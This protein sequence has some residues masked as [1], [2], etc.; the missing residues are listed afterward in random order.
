[1]LAKI[2]KNKPRREQEYVIAL[3]R[4]AAADL[5][6]GNR[7]SA[8]LVGLAVYLKKKGDNRLADKYM[9]IVGE[10]LDGVVPGEDLG[11]LL[12]EIKEV[13][14]DLVR[15]A[16]DKRIVNYIVLVVLAAAAC[17]ATLAWRRARRRERERYEANVSLNSSVVTRDE[18]IRQLL[19]ICSAYQ[20]ASAAFSK[21]VARKI[22]ANQGADLL[23]S[24]ESG[25]VRRE[26]ASMFL[27][28]FD[29]M[30][31]K[32]FPYFIKEL[33]LLLKP[34]EQIEYKEGQPLTTE[35]RIVAFMKLGVTDTDRLARFLDVSRNTIYSYRNRMR[36]RALNRETF[37]SDVCVVSPLPSPEPNPEENG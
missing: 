32:L 35:L 6:M 24:I 28:A 26:N 34:E 36:T 30:V 9:A 1:M 22:K 31:N 33:N 37:E 3:S 18:Y 19:E 7:A 25:K 2:Y 16:R 5:E 13:H 4:A 17:A 10:T 21:T 11:D 20:D 15:Q 8:S 14:A 27:S 23:E 29:S 12:P